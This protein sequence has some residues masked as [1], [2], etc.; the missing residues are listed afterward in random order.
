MTTMKKILFSVLLLMGACMEA[1][2]QTEDKT[3]VIVSDWHL[4]DARSFDANNYYAWTNKNRD[5]I[6]NFLNKLYANPSSCDVLVL[7]GDIFEL[8]RT[9]T[10]VCMVADEQGKLLDDVQYLL[11]IKEQNADIFAA[12]QKLHDA[13]KEIVYLPGNHDLTISKEDMEAAFPGLFTNAFDTPGTGLYEPFGPNSVVAIEHGSRYDY[14]NA[15]YPHGEMGT[16]NVRSD[17]LLPPGYFTSKLGASATVYKAA[18]QRKKTRGLINATETDEGNRTLVSSFWN[19]I[20]VGVGA[21]D[22]NVSTCIDGV[23]DENH[24]VY[25]WEEYA[26]TETNNPVLYAD[27]WTIKNWKKRCEYNKVPVEIPLSTGLLTGI[28]H[29]YTTNL[30]FT[31]RLCNPKLPTLICVF[32]HTHSKLVETRHDAL[33]GDVVYLNDGT[34]VD[35]MEYSTYGVIRYTA[36]TRQYEI[37]VRKYG[38]DD[39]DSMLDCR[40]LYVPENYLLCHSDGSI[41]FQAKAELVE[42]GANGIGGIKESENIKPVQK[43][44]EE[45]QIYILRDGSR[46]NVAGQQ[47]A[48]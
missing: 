14:F 15:P 37:Q 26:V 25:K 21:P 11:R 4:S 41:E 2:A 12:L 8:W 36:A 19:A 23:G 20:H 32:A 10:N 18:Q 45:G 28:F 13:G 27:S 3:V 44:L 46:Y 29:D 40:Y 31:Q 22:F 9:P 35:E 6:V 47:M 30:A 43:V 24:P 7:N 1:A 39:T 42:S 34:W 17:A 38:R 33:K 48:K 5:R 16:A